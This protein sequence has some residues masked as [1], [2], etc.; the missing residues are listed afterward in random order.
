M[1]RPSLQPPA[2]AARLLRSVL[3]APSCEAILG[4]MH[5]TFVHIAGEHG[6]PAA[7]FWYWKEALMALPGFTLLALQNTRTRRQTVNGNLVS[8]NWLDNGRKA[9][10]LG[11]LLLV[12]ALIVEGFAVAYVLSGQPLAMVMNTP[13]LSH[14][15]AAMES[16]ALNVAGVQLPIGILV[17]AGIL[18][19]AVINFFAVVQIKLETVEDGYK[20]TVTARRKLWNLLLLALVAVLLL[21]MDWLIT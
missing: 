7:Q 15:M 19:A 1:K 14:L 16:G 20:A 4:D 9:A 5:E 17:L 3:P 13:G 21:G 6:L 12:P 2:L 18:L 8:E 10:A 11:L